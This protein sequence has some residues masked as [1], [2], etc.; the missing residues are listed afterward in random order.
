MVEIQRL[1]APT[2]QGRGLFSRAAEAASCKLHS[3]LHDLMAIPEDN[4]YTTTTHSFGETTVIV[5][6]IP[7]DYYGTKVDLT[8]CSSW[9]AGTLFCQFSCSE[10]RA[11]RV[12]FGK[13][14]SVLELGSGA[15]LAGIALAKCLERL[16]EPLGITVL[17]DGEA[18]VVDLLRSNVAANGLADRVD[19]QQLWWGPSPQLE[20][21]KRRHPKGFDVIIGCDLFYNQLQHHNGAV[22]GAFFVVDA[23]LSRAEGA[24]MF[25]ACTRRDLDLAVV[26]DAAQARGFRAELQEDFVYDIFNANTDGMTDL[27][28]DAIFAFF[29]ITSE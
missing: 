8:G 2:T 12:T 14:K 6:S 24:C 22:S 4:G 10:E 11:A 17:T 27:W 26:L 20:D 28:R 21:L 9:F 19:C 29:R 1:L 7:K 25:L 16:G 3:L 5:R 23:L 13:G 18:K 15:G